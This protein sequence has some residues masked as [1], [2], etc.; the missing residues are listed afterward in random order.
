MPDARHR[1]AVTGLGTVSAAGFGAAD[2]AEQ[3]RESRPMLSEIDRSGGYHRSSKR[4]LA[5]LIDAPNFLPWLSPMAARRMC[6][7]SKFAVVAAKL[8][9]ED[10][11][12]EPDQMDLATTAVGLATSFGPTDYSERI[13]KGIYEEG[14]EATSPALFTESVANAPAA[15]VALTLKALGPNLTV[16]Q[17]EAGPLIAVASV[18]REVAAGRSRVGLAGAVDEANPILHAV[19]ERFG[20]LAGPGDN[21]SENARPFDRT[22]D[23]FNLAEGAAVLVL[24]SE[25]RA[26][27]RGVRPLAVLRASVAGFDPDAPAWGWSRRPDTLAGRLRSGLA[28]AGI[29]LDEIDRIVSGASGSRYGDLL[30]GRILRQL[31]PGVTPPILAPKGVV[32][33]YGGGHLAA[34]V[35]AAAGRPFGPT[36]GFSEPDPDIDLRPHDGSELPPPRN[37]LVS[38]LAAGGAAAWAVLEA[39]GR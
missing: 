19:L 28:A 27:E 31:W 21:G 20:A 23:G 33:E 34:A 35:L 4:R 3:L 5:A 6:R 24:E 30:E 14:P 38:S 7:P 16:T 1:V 11:A 9:L 32:G 36:V 10:A 17:R 8:A 37:L 12:L 18:A 26:R 22:R 25:E 13:V 29:E 15:Q 2:L 39:G